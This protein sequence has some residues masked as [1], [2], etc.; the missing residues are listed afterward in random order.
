MPTIALCTGSH[1]LYSRRPSLSFRFRICSRFPPF[2]VAL[3]NSQKSKRKGISAPAGHTRDKCE[4]VAMHQNFRI[5][6]NISPA[7]IHPQRETSNYLQFYSLSIH[8]VAC[9]LFR[10]S[11]PQDVT[12]AI[13]THCCPSAEGPLVQRKLSRPLASRRMTKQY[14]CTDLHRDMYTA[15]MG[16]IHI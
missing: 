7:I 12:H 10:N 11:L 6:L 5:L 8:D 14:T 3:H 1:R 9:I 15:E 13:K 2:S 16:K 4:G